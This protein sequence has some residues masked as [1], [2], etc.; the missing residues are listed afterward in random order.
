MDWEVDETKTIILRNLNLHG[1]IIPFPPQDNLNRSLVMNHC[2]F[3]PP[4]NFTKLSFDDASKGNP[5]PVSF[6]G[7]LEIIS[8]PL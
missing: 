5:G 6:G 3:P 7:F 8:Y 4:I 1:K 2:Y